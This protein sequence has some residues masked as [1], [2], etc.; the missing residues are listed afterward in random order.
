MVHCFSINGC[1][2]VL[3]VVSGSVHLVDELA[4]EVLQVLP[5]ELPE[6]ESFIGENVENLRIVREHFPGKDLDGVI[7]ELN[8][9]IQKG[10]LF[11][12]LSSSARETE[13]NFA[14][15]VHDSSTDICKN[16]ENNKKNDKNNKGGKNIIKA[17]CLH[18]A[19][20]CNLRCGY[21]FAGEGDYG[22]ITRNLMSLEIGKKAI[23]FLITNSGGRRNLEVDFFGGEPTINFDVVEGIVSYAREREA[24]TGKN[25]RFTLTTNGLLL[26]NDKMEY[27]NANIDNVVLSLDGRKEINDKMRKRHDGSG[28]YDAILPKFQKMAKMT[29]SSKITKNRCKSYY[30]RGTYT[31]ENLDFCNDVLHLADLGFSQISVEPVVAPPTASYAIEWENVPALCKEYERLA[32]EMLTRDFNFFHFMLDMTNGPCAAK[33]ITGCGAGTE[34]LAVT[35]EGDL[36]PCH[37]FVSDKA[38]FLGNLDT[39]V[40]NTDWQKEFSKCNVYTKPECDKCWAKYFCSGGCA[41]NAYQANGDIM[42]PEEIGCELQKKRVECALYLLAMRKMKSRACSH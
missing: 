7:K 37:Q 21:C 42:K 6:G 29:E 8:T 1:N 39:G 30:I 40:V 15:Q 9:L 10:Q 36:Y 13:I 32:T 28:C 34:Y 38:F 31:K 35:P 20:D 26:D 19:H 3:D 41:A 5:K 27:I 33:R 11:S 12:T 24:E 18:I 14:R 22:T 17:L 25:F 23:D 2:I 4:Y 16:S